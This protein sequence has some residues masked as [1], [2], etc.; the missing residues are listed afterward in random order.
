[1]TGRSP[2]NPL[3][4]SPLEIVAIPLLL[5]ALVGVGVLWGAGVVIGSLAGSTLPGTVGEG[6]VAMVGSFPDIGAAWEP[7]I[8][9][10]IIW[11]TALSVAGLLAPLV[12]K[13][14]RSGTLHDQ[15]AQWATISNLRRARLL[16][17]ETTPPHSIPET[18]TKEQG[19]AD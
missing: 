2:S 17:T 1:M 9:S 10:I 13:M 18:H 15:G 7:P 12:W 4:R 16:V 14:A 19:D 11:A 5:S 6:I 3:G 8:P